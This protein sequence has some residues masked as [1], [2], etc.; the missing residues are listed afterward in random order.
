MMPAGRRTAIAVTGLPGS[1]KSLVAR[2]IAEEL[3][4]PLYVMGDLVRR[5]VKRRGLPLTYENVERVAREL[6]ERYGRAAV[7][8][9]LAREL[10]GVEGPVVVDGLR[11]VEEARLLESRGWRVVIVAVFSPRRLRASRIA[12]RGRAGEAGDPERLVEERDRANI[13]FGV[14]EAMALAD[15]MIVN[16]GG[17]EELEMEARRIARVAVCG[18]GEDRG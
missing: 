10:E 17:V 9:L 13:E 5:E 6:R 3:G 2:F 7:A 14:A 15:Y 18:E 16:T 8:Q 4:A 11:S 12:A 1:G